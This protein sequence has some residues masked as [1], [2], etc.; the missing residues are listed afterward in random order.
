[1]GEKNSEATVSKNGRGHVGT[2][3][4]FEKTWRQQN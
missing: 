4:V 1:M 3:L 2:I